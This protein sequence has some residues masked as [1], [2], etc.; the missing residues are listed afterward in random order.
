MCMA[1]SRLLILI[2][3]LNPGIL[4]ASKK[5][6]TVNFADAKTSFLKQ[7]AL[8]LTLMATG[9]LLYIGDIKENIQPKFPST[10]T[11]I[12]NIL[13]YTPMVQIYA[14]DALGFKHKSSVWD[15]TKYLLISQLISAPTVQILKGITKVKRPDG[16]NNYSFPSG[17]TANA[18]TGA[19]VL[20]HEFKDTEPLLAWSGYMVA[21]ATGILRIT[22][23]EHW[24]PDVLVGAGIGIISANLVYHFEPL[25]NWQPFKTKNKD[26]A[27]TP[28]IS[29]ASVGLHVRF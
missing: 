18:F 14:Y 7:Q 4:L 29:P 2:A 12:D 9:G 5:D 13:E 6:T 25:K 1:K 15:Q 23:N 28:L 27:F 20:Y 16:S 3:F 24:L 19:T 10:S 22:N 21:T 8:P 17:H 11:S 26:I